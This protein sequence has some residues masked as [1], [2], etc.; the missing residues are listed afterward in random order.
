M[1]IMFICTG[2]ICRSAMADWLLKQ[3]IKDKNIK[4]IEVYSCGVYA[5]DG[6]TPTWE[7]KRVMADEYSI[8]MS[9]H[10]ATNI[11]NSNIE[12]MDLIL[13]ATRYHKRDVL[14]LYPEDW[15]WIKGYKNGI[16][17]NNGKI[18]NYLKR[19]TINSFI[20]NK[21]YHTLIANRTVFYGINTPAKNIF[22]LEKIENIVDLKNLFGRAGR[23]GVYNYGN[24]F[25]E[26]DE[27]EI[28]EKEKKYKFSIDFIDNKD[29]YKEEKTEKKLHDLIINNELPK[30]PFSK[31]NIN[32]LIELILEF[33]STSINNDI[34]KLIFKK[35]EI[36][37][38]NNKK[39]DNINLFFTK[40]FIENVLKS[41]LFIFNIKH[42]FNNFSDK[43]LS[44]L[45]NYLK[46]YSIS[47]IGKEVN[48]YKTKSDW[49]NFYIDMFTSYIPH[50]FILG[51]ELCINILKLIN[52]KDEF[53]NN[54]KLKQLSKELNFIYTLITDEFYKVNQNINNKNKYIGIYQDLVE[55][56]YLYKDI[57]KY[58]NYIYD[59]I[60]DNYETADLINIMNT[61]KVYNPFTN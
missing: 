8:D 61:L 52:E 54:H 21:D 40:Y 17:I 34:W 49:I 26:I 39:N 6:D 47:D 1:K 9:Q 20:N 42:F 5:E 4:D 45:E 3:K 51:L 24:I 14:E 18:P 27:N 38:N 60:S 58:I 36:F 11:R 28:L 48:K 19:F 15:F 22:I 30:S 23:Y 25:A 2:N 7:A 57:E 35:S 31:N 33:I 41:K 50:K 55:L 56:G 29:Q 46:K 16:L 59:K 10:R 37:N 53:I 12:K 13:C 43:F 44:Y 32:E